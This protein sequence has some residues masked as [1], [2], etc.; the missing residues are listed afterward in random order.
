MG[1]RLKSSALRRH[2]EVH[3]RRGVPVQGDHGVPCVQDAEGDRD[4]PLRVQDRRAGA[5][6]QHG[7]A[8]A[9]DV[10]VADRVGVPALEL[11]QG[12]LQTRVVHPHLRVGPQQQHP[13]LRSRGRPQRPPDEGRRLAADGHGSTSATRAISRRCAP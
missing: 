1:E 13:A 9:R 5:P 4:L 7:C 2:R 3:D 11:L 8:G 10:R 6:G 12:R